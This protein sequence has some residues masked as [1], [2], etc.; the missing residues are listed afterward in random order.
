MRLAGA[1]ALARLGP[2]LGTM[3]DESTSVV[4]DDLTD[5]GAEHFS[6]ACRLLVHRPLRSLNV[7]MRRSFGAPRDWRCQLSSGIIADRFDIHRV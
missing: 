2:Q 6:C 4:E 5:F 3:I 7:Q 1:R